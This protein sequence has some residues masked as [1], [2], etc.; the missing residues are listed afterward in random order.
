MKKL[1]K[2][3]VKGATKEALNI[4]TR[5]VSG[6]LT[7]LAKESIKEEIDKS[8]ITETVKQNLIRTATKFKEK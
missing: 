2:R 3:I 5:A 6:A 1:S 8:G 7:D 4:S